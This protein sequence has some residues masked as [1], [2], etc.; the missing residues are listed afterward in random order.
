MGFE[1][2]RTP[3]PA[4]VFKADPLTTPAPRH[5]KDRAATVQSPTKQARFCYSQ[6]GF[7]SLTLFSRIS[8]LSPDSLPSIDSTAARRWNGALLGSCVMRYVFAL[9]LLFCIKP[10]SASP[11][12]STA[13]DGSSYFCALGTINLASAEPVHVGDIVELVA[14][15]G[16]PGPFSNPTLWD[17]GVFDGLLI[18]SGPASFTFEGTFNQAGLWPLFMTFQDGYG[19]EGCA[20][21]GPPGCGSYLIEVLPAAQVTPVPEPSTWAMLLIGFA[22]VG[23]AAFRRRLK[24]A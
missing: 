5:P 1:P 3:H 22:G 4:T 18:S 9:F 16:G 10:A 12:Y 17:Y 23:F 11:C 15:V 6:C 19:N 20:G 21:G 14:I 2:T 13:P 24:P 8:R 7:F